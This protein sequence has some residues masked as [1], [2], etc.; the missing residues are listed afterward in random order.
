VIV[1][2]KSSS[3]SSQPFY[4]SKTIDFDNKV[5]KDIN[6]PTDITNVFNEVACTDEF[7]YIRNKNG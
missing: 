2:G 5:V 4:V 7:L 1:Y 6:F 3:N